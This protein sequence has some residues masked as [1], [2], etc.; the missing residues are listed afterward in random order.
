MDMSGT[1]PW[2]EADNLPL[3]T[4]QSNMCSYK[5]SWPDSQLGTGKGLSYTNRTF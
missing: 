3:S 5:S 2:G 4:A 1:V